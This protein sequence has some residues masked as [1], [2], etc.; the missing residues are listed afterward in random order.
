MPKSVYR[1]KGGT[2]S[3][4]GAQESRRRATRKE[5]M[6]REKKDGMGKRLVQREE[7]VQTEAA[8]RERTNLWHGKTPLRRRT[9]NV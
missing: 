4:Y 3:R 7:Q 1:D 5:D 2:K 6:E 9:E 8:G